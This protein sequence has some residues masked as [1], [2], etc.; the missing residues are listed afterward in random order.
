MKVLF[1]C[2]INVNRSQIAAAIFNRMSKRNHATSAGMSP[3]IGNVGTLIKKD[4][5]SPIIPMKEYG[6][7]LSHQRVRK[8]NKQMA[9]KVDKIVL[10]FSKKKYRGTLP[11]YLEKLPDV[12]WWDVSSIS[13]ETPFDEYCRLETKRIKKISKLVKGLVE[14][15][16]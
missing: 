1:V 5:L 6:Y 11:S 16:G 10:I 8:L 2:R 7:D 9:E 12:E 13:D 14:R 3:K 15:I 4:P